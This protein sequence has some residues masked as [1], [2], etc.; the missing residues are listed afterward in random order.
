MSNP[1]ED[2]IL[3]IL[4]G[5]AIGDALG[6]P[7]EFTGKD[8]PRT[9][10]T[11]LRF[12]GSDRIEGLAPYLPNIAAGDLGYDKG[13]KF[14]DQT[15]VGS[16]TDDTTMLGVGAEAITKALKDKTGMAFERTLLA[17][18][19][20][21]Y[22][23]WCVPQRGGEGATEYIDKSI[24]WSE[25]FKSLCF[26]CGA[27]FGTVY[28]LASGK[29]GTIENP[30]YSR[31]KPSKGG[32][33]QAEDKLVKGCGGM[34]RAAILAAV[35]SNEV[36]DYFALGK[37][38]AAITHGD[39][40][41]YQSTGVI[42]EMASRLYHGASMI[43]ALDIAYERLIHENADSDA[44]YYFE[45]GMHA[46]RDDKAFDMKTMDGLVANLKDKFLAGPV[47]AQV[48]YVLSSIKEPLGNP[49]KIKDVLRLAVTH[50]GDTDS[51]GA[52]VG[53]LVGAKYGYKALPQD[54]T[55][56]IIS[57][58]ALIA[59][60][61]DLARTIQERGQASVRGFGV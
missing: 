12:I 8:K 40:T 1:Y 18:T 53:A 60:G 41:A 20:Q 24:D 9:L 27:G 15:G 35:P 16:I 50:C 29:M 51:V 13:E 32:A 43:E 56:K 45:E 6:A 26:R 23:N 28:V 22:L 14:A 57:K 44:R 11:V 55:D 46:A 21:A 33:N 3:G 5:S 7:H 38:Q 39:A 47:L 49:E 17:K 58:D 36:I 61:Q 30:V 52:I 19:H 48:I 59:I 4:L 34:M 10:E 42:A 31:L 54:W 2:K 37:K 25:S